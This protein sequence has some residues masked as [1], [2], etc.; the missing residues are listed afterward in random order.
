LKTSKRFHFIKLFIGIIFVTSFNAV[1][2]GPGQSNWNFVGNFFL[3]KITNNWNHLV[4]VVK[5]CP[6]F[7]KPT[8][9]KLA[10]EQLLKVLGFNAWAWIV[11]L[12]MQHH[13][14]RRMKIYKG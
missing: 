2:G 3:K 6:P 4:V 13:R 11:C 7:P 12:E 8:L 10:S 9:V 14:W 1:G 5:Q